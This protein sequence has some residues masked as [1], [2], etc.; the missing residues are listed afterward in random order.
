MKQFDQQYVGNFIFMIANIILKF[1]KDRS[2]KI[3]VDKHQHIKQPYVTHSV[4]TVLHVY[5]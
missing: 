2:S 3:C 4:N 5:K 1:H